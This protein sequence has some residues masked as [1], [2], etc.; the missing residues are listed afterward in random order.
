MKIISKTDLLVCTSWQDLMRLEG[1]MFRVTDHKEV[2]NCDDN[3]KSTG[4]ARFIRNTVIDTNI[5]NCRTLFIFA[6]AVKALLSC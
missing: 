1:W 5:N 6:V 2:L 3:K 4:Y